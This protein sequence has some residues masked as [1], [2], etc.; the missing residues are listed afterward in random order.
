MVNKEKKL[1]VGTL[2]DIMNCIAN[3]IN[4]GR[5]E[6]NFSVWNRPNDFS[7]DG[8]YSGIII[9]SF[10]GS[11]SQLKGSIIANGYDLAKIAEMPKTA[12]TKRNY[13]F[14]KHD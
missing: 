1:F 13:Y 7:S 5:S 2:N 9:Y 4:N 11:Q 12:S 14:D 8:S 10:S 3:R 6:C